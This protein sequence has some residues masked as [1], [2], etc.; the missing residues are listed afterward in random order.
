MLEKPKKLEKK[1]R[2]EAVERMGAETL[3]KEIDRLPDSKKVGGFLLTTF[4]A[5]GLAMAGAGSAEAQVRANRFPRGGPTSG[6]T[7]EI[8]QRGRIGASQAMERRRAEAGAKINFEYQKKF[9]EIDAMKNQLAQEFKDTGISARE[10]EM[11]RQQLDNEVYRL[12]RERDIKLM[13]PLGIKGRILEGV[14]RGY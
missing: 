13:N 6:I 9:Q 11:R 7:G 8:F 1:S 4:L 3:S 5:M 2:P 10:F 12:S 14:I